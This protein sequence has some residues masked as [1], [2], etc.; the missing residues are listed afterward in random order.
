MAYV[1][2]PVLPVPLPYLLLYRIYWVERFQDNSQVSFLHDSGIVLAQTDTSS[3]E[4]DAIKSKVFKKLQGPTPLKVLTTF[5]S[6]KN[7]L[8][9]QMLSGLSVL[10]HY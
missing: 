5:N 2:P 4:S 7:H 6:H 8:E 9:L 10:F 3:Y 1:L